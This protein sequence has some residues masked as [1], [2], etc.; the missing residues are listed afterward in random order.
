MHRTILVVDDEPNSRLG[1]SDTLREWG[2]GTIVVDT[3][4]NGRK[5]LDM[6][7][8]RNVDLLITDIRMPVM[9]G[10]RLLTELRGENRRIKTILLSGYAEF[11]Y[12]R[13]GLRLGAIDYLLKP[14]QQEQLIRTVEKALES[15]MREEETD[16][17]DGVMGKSIRNDNVRKAL[18]CIHARIQE[19]LTIK[20]VA[21]QVH[22][23][24]SYFSV[25]FKEETGVNFTDYLTMYRIRKAKKLLLETD[26]G[27]DEISERIGYQTTS[28][29]IKTFKKLE[30]M[31][32]NEFRNRTKNGKP[33]MPQ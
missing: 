12:A 21:R 22:L 4:E 2:G 9:D 11:E 19:P 28:Y 6:I 16:A 5:A 26:A 3:A 32:P 13:Q 14:V 8:S 17:L 7:R 18:D 24:P 29:F 31:T 27:L 25:L 15:D 10:L 33:V 20:E 30:Q 1:V 23:N